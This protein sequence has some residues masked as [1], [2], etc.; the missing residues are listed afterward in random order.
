[1]NPGQNIKGK[2]GCDHGLY[3]GLTMG[4]ENP[5]SVGLYTTESH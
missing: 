5:D 3:H 4:G 1:M 2:T